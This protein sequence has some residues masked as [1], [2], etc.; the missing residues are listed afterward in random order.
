LGLSNNGNLGIGTTGPSAELDVNG[1]IRG[2]AVYGYAEHLGLPNCEEV[3]EGIIA[4]RIAAHAADLAKGI[5]NAGRRDYSISKFRKQR[6]WREQINM[7]L[8]PRRA[9][10]IHSRLKSNIADIC[11]M[12]GE[13]CPMRIT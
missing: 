6:K 5:P 10:M 11:S 1:R 2:N 3:K 12:C 7:S 8:D 13:F 4:T 9:R